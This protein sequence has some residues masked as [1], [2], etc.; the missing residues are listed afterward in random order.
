MARLKDRERQIPNGLTFYQSALKWRP[1]PYS[2]FD[3][4]TRGL[5]S[6]RRANPFLARKNGW[7]VDYATVANEVDEYNAKICESHHWDQYIVR[8]GGPVI[9]PSRARSN[10]SLSQS[11]GHVAAGV[12]ITMEMFGKEGPIRDRDL[13]LRRAQ[14]CVGC[15]NNDKGD[16]TRFFTVPTQAVI[17]K[18]LGIIK[19]LDLTTAVDDQLQVCTV[20]GCPLKGKV[21]AR[22][23]HIL[24][25]MPKADLAKL[26]DFCWIVREKA[27]WKPPQ[28]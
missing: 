21:Y 2:S 11:V 20:C 16:W 7:S 5:I 26:P 23:S 19:D 10:S 1:P 3:T 28:S 9:P 6:A 27:E 22:L 25:F 24:K 15:P 18:G 17:R 12:S 14:V 13:A 8:D 4:I